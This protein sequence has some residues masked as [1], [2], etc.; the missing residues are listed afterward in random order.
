MSLP[1]DL[2]FPE[3]VGWFSH[4]VPRPKHLASLPRL[5]EWFGSVYRFD[6]FDILTTNG[7]IDS[8]HSNS[9]TIE[10]EGISQM[11]E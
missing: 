2:R 8:L 4:T 3:L 7:F 9:V 6:R 11:D 5:Y 1:I 10:K